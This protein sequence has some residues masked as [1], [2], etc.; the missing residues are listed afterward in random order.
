MEELSDDVKCPHCGGVQ[1]D[2]WELDFGCGL[3]G[4]TS[5]NCAHCEAEF[6]VERSVSVYYRS[7]GT[8]PEVEL[9]KK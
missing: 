8:P 5:M 1:S 7:W 9:W 2:V 3:E 4:T 6:N